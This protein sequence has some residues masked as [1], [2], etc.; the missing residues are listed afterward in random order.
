MVERVLEFQ[1]VPRRT[2]HLIHV[3]VEVFLRTAVANDHGA[4]ALIDLA[5]ESKRIS[6][7][8]IACS[9]RMDMTTFFV[10]FE[11]NV[12]YIELVDI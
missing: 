10:D 4:M 12:T 5:C 2:T 8:M 7:A 6:A 9:L 11:T 1:E 3:T